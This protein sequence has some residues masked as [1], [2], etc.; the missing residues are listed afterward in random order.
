M[1]CCVLRDLQHL[2][3][4]AAFSVIKSVLGDWEH[5]ELIESVLRDGGRVLR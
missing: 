5:L 2:A 1:I 4:F 3:R